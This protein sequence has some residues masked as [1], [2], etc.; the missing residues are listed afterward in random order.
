MSKMLKTPLYSHDVK[1]NALLFAKLLEKS[2]S[3]KTGTLVPRVPKEHLFSHGPHIWLNPNLF[4]LLFGDSDFSH[5]VRY[6]S[7]IN[8]FRNMAVYSYR[9]CLDLDSFKVFTD[10]NSLCDDYVAKVVFTAKENGE[11]IPNVFVSANFYFHVRHLMGGDTLP[12]LTWSTLTIDTITPRGFIKSI[13]IKRES[14]YYV[15]SIL[16][17]KEGVI[18][19]ALSRYLGRV[20]H[21]GKA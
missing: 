19:R 4:L 10:P 5:K 8:A 7:I 6:K 11:T 13:T 14:C 18:E 1:A 17:N 9:D 2:I 12:I 20:V 21:L 16:A 3:G 15:P